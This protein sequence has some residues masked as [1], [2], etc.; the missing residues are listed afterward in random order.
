M[1]I[2]CTL[3]L[4]REA[5]TVPLVRTICRD[6]LE[7]LGVASECRAD[8]VLALTE[9]C[10]NV[11]QH[12]DGVTGYEVHIELH[13]DFCHIR[14]LDAGQGL[15]TEAVGEMPDPSRDHGRGIALMNLLVDRLDFDFQPERGT[16][17]HLEK[18]LE[19]EESSPLGTPL[20]RT[21]QAEGQPSS[22]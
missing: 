17:V 22:R 8:V 16:T 11:I 18:A 5:A 13:S 3:H 6:A 12:A 15:R 10:A 4:P 7:R 9:A 20:R 19:L 21:L 14:V 2:A 1:D